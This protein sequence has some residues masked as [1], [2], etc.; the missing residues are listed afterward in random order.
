MGSKKDPKVKNKE[1]KQEEGTFVKPKLKKSEAV[2]RDIKSAEVEKVRLKSHAFEM[3][4]QD[5][6]MEQKSNIRLHKPIQSLSEDKGEKKEKKVVKKK[7]KKEPN[8]KDSE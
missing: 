1:D 5:V 8:A 3:H 4:P 7:K 6:P 2:K